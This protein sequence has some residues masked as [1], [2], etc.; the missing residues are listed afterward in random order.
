MDKL[1]E[2]TSHR[3]T[4]R[5]VYDIHILYNRLCTSKLRTPYSGQVP[6]ASL[7]VSSMERC[8]HIRYH[9][10]ASRCPQCR[11]LTT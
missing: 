3:Y 7:K 4:Y 10:P 9:I 2:F 5:Y 6:C 1:M 8:D 11:G